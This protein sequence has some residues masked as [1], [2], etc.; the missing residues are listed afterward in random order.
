MTVFEW[1]DE[2]FIFCTHFYSFF[3]CYVANRIVQNNNNIDNMYNI[4]FKI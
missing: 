4:Y 2:Y 3:F 1:H